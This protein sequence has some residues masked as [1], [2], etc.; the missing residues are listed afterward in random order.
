MLAD[1]HLERLLPPLL[2]REARHAGYHLFRLFERILAS[3]EFWIGTH[4]GVQVVMVHLMYF[5]LIHALRQFQQH[6]DSLKDVT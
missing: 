2:R 6:I 5:D 4:E 3:V 1:S